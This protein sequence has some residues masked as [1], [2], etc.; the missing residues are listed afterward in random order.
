MGSPQHVP[1]VERALGTVV[2]SGMN[3]FQYV[4]ALV[5][6]CVRTRRQCPERHD[7]SLVSGPMTEDSVCCWR[8]AGVV[9]DWVLPAGF[10]G[11]RRGR[12]AVSHKGFCLSEGLSDRVQERCES[13]GGRPG[14]SVLTSLMVFEDVKQH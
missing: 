3:S 12:E 13:R 7:K 2:L 10:P 11:L 9:P 1:H 8:S 4:P 5:G 6:T 14:L